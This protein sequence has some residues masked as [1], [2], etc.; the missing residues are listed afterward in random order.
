MPSTPAR[1]SAGINTFPFAHAM[2]TFPV[3]TTQFQINKGDDFIPFRTSDYTATGTG[4]GAA[5][6]AFGWNGGA[7]KLTA[8]ST[9]TQKSFLALGANSLQVIPG[10]QLWHDVRVGVSALAT[11]S[12]PTTDA[13]IFCGLFDNADPTLALNGIYFQKPSGGSAVNFVVMKGGIAAPVQ[14]APSTATTG[15]TIA[16]NTYYLVVTALTA[17]G[18]TVR[19]NEQS[20][21]TTGATST[22]TVNWAAVPGAASYRVYLGTAAGVETT[23]F[24]VAG[25]ATITTTLTSATGTA[26]SPPATN[27]SGTITTFQN[28]GDFGLPSG[29]YGDPGSSNGSLTFNT[30]GTTF[31]SVVVGA[32]GGGYRVAPLVNLTGT[33]GSGGQ[34]ICQLGQ[35]AGLAG[36]D[37]QMASSALYAPYITAPGSGYTAGTLGADIIPWINLQFYYDGK[38]RLLVAMNG[39]AV[40]ALDAVGVLTAA[41][42]ATYN[43]ATAANASY[44]FAGTTLSAGVAPIQPRPG[45][46]YVALPQVPLQLAFGLYGTAAN[47]RALYVEEINVGTELI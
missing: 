3:V 28:V 20:Q 19:S 45:D 24:A 23:Y 39:R 13:V 40:M 7:V 27:T 15:G 18:E 38:G 4:T 30:T 29:I 34:A 11:Q 22:I 5:Q 1:F 21:V 32:A 10:N 17:T 25:G 35:G 9:L 8:G 41:P 36:S 12:N 26:G 2:R 43:V 47:N 42:G 37:S 33:A 14:A 6:A 44:S 31:T 16:A 46:P